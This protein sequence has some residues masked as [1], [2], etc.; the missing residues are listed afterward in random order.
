[1]KIR[2]RIPNSRGRSSQVKVKLDVSEDVSEDVRTQAL[3]MAFPRLGAV[4]FWTI[5]S[6]MSVTVLVM[7]SPA[8]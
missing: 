3:V 1:M 8:K 6:W 5:G 4:R 7:D 2:V